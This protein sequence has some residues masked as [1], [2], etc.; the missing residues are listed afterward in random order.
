MSYPFVYSIK[1]VG[2]AGST[3][4]MYEQIG[5]SMAGVL[6]KAVFGMLIWANASGKVCR[7]IRY[8]D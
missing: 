3:A 7:G 4:I 8:V 1:T 2:S 5:Y 6:A